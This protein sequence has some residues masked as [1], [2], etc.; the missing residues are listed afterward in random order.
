MRWTHAMAWW[1]ALLL[2]GCVP[3][4]GGWSVQA[5][6]D[7]LQ[8]QVK[9]QGRLTDLAPQP[10]VQGMDLILFLC[11]WETDQPV[12]VVFPQDASAQERQMLRVVL[13]NWANS[14]LGI[15]FVEATASPRGIEI[16]FVSAG[17]PVSIPQGAGDALVN[18][19]VEPS[20]VENG[21]VEASLEFASVYL[22][23]DQ[24]DLLGR[25]QPMSWDERYGTALH[26]L[27]HALGFSSHVAH[28]GSVMT[29]SPA[30]VRRVGAEL[31]AGDWSGDATLRALYSVPSGT[32]VGTRALP[33]EIAGLMKRFWTGA[34]NLGLEGP[35]TRV[36]DQGS[37]IFYRG[38]AGETFA[39]SI[40][41][42]PPSEDVPLLQWVLNARAQRLMGPARP[43][44]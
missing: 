3:S 24:D 29:R 17:D 4:R 11:R 43:D 32:V 27:G 34:E 22:R 12:P 6:P 44:E 18:C 25:S 31:Q 5:L 7:S 28:G 30:V 14:G 9:K 23:R 40:R 13:R 39:V 33:A 15:R 37:R 38:A 26:E 19:R 1:F 42:W 41:P 21:K 36:G 2:I 20:S 10:W 35:F 8:V 16:K